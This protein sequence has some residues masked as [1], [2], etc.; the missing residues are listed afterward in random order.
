MTHFDLELPMLLIF[1]ILTFYILT[2][3]QR[4]KTSWSSKKLELNIGALTFQ[5]KLMKRRELLT[6][7][8]KAEQKEQEKIRAEEHKVLK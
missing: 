3:R 1:Y 5:E 7:K 4:T 6:E 8:M 2:V